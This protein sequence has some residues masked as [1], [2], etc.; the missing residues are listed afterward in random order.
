VDTSV[1]TV[2]AGEQ[3]LVEACR[4]YGE[5][6]PDTLAA[7][8]ALAGLYR[9]ARRF[10]EAGAQLQVL[11]VGLR[12]RHEPDHP[13]ILDAQ[14]RLAFAY[15][16]GDRLAEAEEAYQAVLDGRARTL[17]ELHP[18]TIAAQ[19]HVAAVRRRRWHAVSG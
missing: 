11:I 16:L 5:D 4:L 14:H 8:S 3:E 10:D 6:H 19:E 7:R 9:R 1:A 18:A 15:R 13:D 2:T 17:G 12:R